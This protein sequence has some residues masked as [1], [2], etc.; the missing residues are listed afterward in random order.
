MGAGY[1]AKF[2]KYL[3][4]IWGQSIMSKGRDPE[5]EAS[6]L[7]RSIPKFKIFT[8]EFFDKIMKG[9]LLLALTL[10]RRRLI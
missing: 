2:A 3:A 10:A 9:L 1:V 7:L 6:S 8:I 4:H 5:Y